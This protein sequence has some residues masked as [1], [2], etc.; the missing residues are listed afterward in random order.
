ML[1][2][3]HMLALGVVTTIFL[4]MIVLHRRARVVQQM[5]QIDDS[6]LSINPQFMPRP[7]AWLAIR[8]SNPKAVQAALGASY[9]APCPWT[10]G[11]TGKHKFFI[12]SPV[13]DWIIVT[14]RG[15]PQPGHDVDRAFHF[16]IHLSRILGQVQFFMA[17]PVLHH[18]AWV[19]WKMAA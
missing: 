4:G 14:G 17:D 15:L 16:L 6:L 11:I 18:H 10:E 8:A 1:L 19:R 2:A 9:P 12:G 13:N 5:F 3:L 7:T